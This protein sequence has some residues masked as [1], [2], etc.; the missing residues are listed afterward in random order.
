MRTLK[1]AKLFLR[2]IL[3]AA[4]LHTDF[5]CATLPQHVQ[6]IKAELLIETEN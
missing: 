1:N 2:K 5:C 3:G 6:T 4:A